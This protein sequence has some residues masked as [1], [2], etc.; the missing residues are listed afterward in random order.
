MNKAEEFLRENYSHQLV[1][2][3]IKFLADM[4]EQYAQHEK[5]KVLESFMQTLD[6]KEDRKA[7]RK[8]RR[9]INHQNQ[10]D[11]DR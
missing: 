6:I 4:L 2:E 10:E 7:I 8:L 9:F 1:H 11:E 3:N 5:N